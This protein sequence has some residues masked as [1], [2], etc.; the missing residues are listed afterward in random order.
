MRKKVMKVILVLIILL[1]G[2]SGVLFV[3]S[4]K[5]SKIE[6]V[7]KAKQTIGKL[8]SEVVNSTTEETVLKLHTEVDLSKGNGKGG[9][10]VWLSCK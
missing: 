2:I 6:M 8:I 1:A 10:H 3:Y 7:E 9:V 4:E 5:V